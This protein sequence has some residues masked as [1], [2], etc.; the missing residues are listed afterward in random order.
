[1]KPV[2]IGSGGGAI[3]AS[4]SVRVPE[5]PDIELYLF[6][7]RRV[8]VGHR[9]T[10]LFIKSPFLL[11]SFEPQP[12]EAVGRSLR[13]VE[14]IGKRIVLDWGEELYFALHLMI[15]GRLRWIEKPNA[16]VPARIG[17][18]A[19]AFD[20]GTLVLVESSPQKRASLHVVR[21]TEN[22][23]QFDRGGL[24]IA[25]TGIAEIYECLMQ[26]GRTLKRALT[27]PQIID[28]I[29]NAY[30]DEILH[31]ARLSP[32]KRT[33]DLTR[34]DVETLVESAT[35]LLRRYTQRLED[36]FRHKFPG[37]G[38]VTAFRPDFAVHGKFAQPCP[39]CG[40]AIQRVRYAQNE[41]NYC[42]R[43]Q[44]GGRILADRSLSRL[45]RDDWPKTVEELE[46]G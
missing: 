43:C 17:L 39:V 28:G 18:A 22:L 5:L 19:L 45:L 26:S 12:D 11:R 21:G 9:L 40:T 42:P 33:R 30:S 6:S 20:N 2:V 15:A 34:Q 41:M 35:A 4:E 38:D 36:E 23:K 44:T 1:M 8:V 16:P 31:A 10:R 29:G 3:S 7:L 37:P 46:G 32:F 13:G 27:D 14:R 24:D 25:T